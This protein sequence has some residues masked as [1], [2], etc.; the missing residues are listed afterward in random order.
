MPEQGANR[1]ATSADEFAA[2]P[3]WR[4]RVLQGLLTAATALGAA[5]AVPSI[6][7]SLS[8]GEWGI[9]VA[10]TVALSFVA[11][12]VFRRSLP[13]V[14][15]AVGFL[16]AFYTIGVFLF[17]VV[18]PVLAAYFLAVPVLA[19]VVLGTRAAVVALVLTTVTTAVLGFLGPFD[20][21]VDA[22]E[23]VSDTV[24][25]LVVTANFAFVS[26]LITASVAALLTRYERSLALNRRLAL[27]VEHSP[28][29]VVICETD[30]AIVYRNS[31]AEAMLEVG[32]P[33][34]STL[35]GLFDG[36]DPPLPYPL[37]TT[38]WRAVVSLGT[39]ADRREL[40]L[41]LLPVADDEGSR[42][43]VLVVRDVTGE[44]AARE[45]EARAGRLQALGTLVAGTAHDFNNALASIVGQ[46]ELLRAE[47]DEPQRVGLD[48]ILH[49]ADRAQG[50]VRQLMAFG[51][52]RPT[53][54]ARTDLGI[55]LAAER[56]GLAALLPAHARLEIE[57]E[58]GL[59]VGLAP[60][61]IHQV[62]SN[63][64]TNAVHAVE[65]RASGTIR[66]A[67]AEAPLDATGGPVLDGPDAEAFAVLEVRDDGHGIDPE[68][69]PTVFDPFVTTKDPAKGTGLGLA[70]VHGV[71]T[72]AGGTVTIASRP[73]DGT[74]VTVR[75]PAWRRPPAGPAVERSEPPDGVAVTVGDGAVPRVLVVDD[76]ALIASST[77][78]LLQRRGYDATPCDDPVEARRLLED[79]AR[80]DI[81]LT[82]V[83]MPTMSGVAFAGAVR[84]LLPEATI[85][86][87][88]GYG[89]VMSA[90]DRAR[91]AI[92]ANVD[93]PFTIDALV[94]CLA[95]A[96]RARPGA[97]GQA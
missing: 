39:G 15:R 22:D 44:R 56:A 2:A 31:A 83:S 28:E 52:V 38:G 84:E 4:A 20:P 86:A 64:V 55:E 12:L 75:L 25:W 95:D 21:L 72:A 16:A 40:D 92:A 74:T 60:S 33:E 57:A 51:Q 32:D 29:A 49:T 97:H 81:V 54:E 71:V 67:V 8:I 78:R 6:G 17:V 34:A 58:P 91:L 10:D 26:G 66:I 46:A 9:A 47:V 62:L 79:G 3:V 13:H 76:E 23:T 37:P 14:V 69:L 77:A 85:V 70:G 88:S 43:Q 96:H 5:V 63:L 94:A 30:G 93:K 68:L 89:D 53:Q 1:E 87:M 73:G 59:H 82:D 35:H 48:G 80:F 36:S 61:E 27:A 50:V 41:L 42:Q 90:D 11:F 24:S 19:A 45:A 18:G 7:F 65:G